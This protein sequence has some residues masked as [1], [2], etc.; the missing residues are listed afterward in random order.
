MKSFDKATKGLGIDNMIAAQAAH[1]WSLDPEAGTAAPKVS[2]RH[3]A[4]P[5]LKF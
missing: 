3:D 2:Q 1:G 5:A 4:A